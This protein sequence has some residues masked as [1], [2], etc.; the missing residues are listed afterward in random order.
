MGLKNELETAVVNEPSVFEPPKFCCTYLRAAR[1]ILLTFIH[2]I[3]PNV[4]TAKIILR[5]FAIK[6][7]VNSNR[8]FRFNQF[9]HGVEA[10]K[11]FRMSTKRN[12]RFETRVN[13]KMA[14]FAEAL[15]TFISGPLYNNELIIVL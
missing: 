2:V 9:Y 3:M 11:H 15:I 6:V 14:A 7:S 1:G 10:H 8:P 12:E 4:A 5:K 13:T